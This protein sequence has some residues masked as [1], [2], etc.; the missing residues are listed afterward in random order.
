[1]SPNAAP[2]SGQL[3]MLGRRLH[4]TD[5]TTGAHS[6][7]GNPIFT[8]HVGQAGPMYIQT[9]CMGCHINNGRG[10]PPAVGQPLA[11]ALIEVGSTADGAPD[12]V[13]GSCL[14]MQNAGGSS[15]GT[16]M[17]ASYTI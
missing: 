11:N 4:H 17:I 7:T 3:F 2:A 12:P 16:A 1:M 9:S 10:L 5:F 14:L 8:N 15:E 13:Y 6:E